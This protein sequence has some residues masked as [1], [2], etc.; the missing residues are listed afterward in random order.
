LEIK[1]NEYGWYKIGMNVVGLR[2]KVV[3]QQRK[4]E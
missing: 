3:G 2:R 1:W 4:M